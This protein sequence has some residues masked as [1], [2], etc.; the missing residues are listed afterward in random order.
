MI[1]SAVKI[2]KQCLQTDSASGGLRPQTW[3]AIA[4]Q[5]NIA[6]AVIAGAVEGLMYVLLVIDTASENNLHQDQ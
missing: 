4:P 1:V 3:W 6:I 5:M 2:C